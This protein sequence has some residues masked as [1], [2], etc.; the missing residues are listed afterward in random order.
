[1]QMGDNRVGGDS[2]F[3]GEMWGGL[4]SVVLYGS[5]GNTLFSAV[6]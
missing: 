6:L 4:L 2:L 5:I 3:E 1:M